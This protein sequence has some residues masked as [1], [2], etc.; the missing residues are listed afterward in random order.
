[1]NRRLFRWCLL[2]G[3]AWLLGSCTLGPVAQP[4]ATATTVATATP[5]V[6]TRWQGQAV[7]GAQRLALWIVADPATRARGLMG[8]ESLPSDT[9]MLFIFP[10]VA[11]R[12]FWMRNTPLPLSIAFLDDAGMILNIADMAPFDEQTLHASA[13]PA[14]YAIEVP[15]GWFAANG[16]TAG[17]VVALELP[18]DL[19]VE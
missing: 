1:M 12:T 7:I 16:I 19:V 17:A 5:A 8:V 6:A 13:G 14:R 4:P 9:G 10:D 3:C 15:Q 11:V 18:P 2:F